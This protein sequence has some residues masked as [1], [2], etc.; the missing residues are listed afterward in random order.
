MDTEQFQKDQRI[1]P[2]ELDLAAATQAETFFYWAE[3]LVKARRAMDRAKLTV[4][5][6]ENDLALQIRTNPEEFSITKVTEGAIGATV[7]THAKY[8]DAVQVLSDRKSQVQMLEAA[9][10]AMEQRKRMIEI[11]VTLHGQ[12]YFAGPSVPRDLVS[13][14]NEDQETRAAELL[15]RQRKRARRRSSDEKTT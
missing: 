10:N 13:A 4:D 15:E 11:L 3:Q 8:R 14:W 5:F 12:Q 9:V 6:V 2:N 1:D 7:K